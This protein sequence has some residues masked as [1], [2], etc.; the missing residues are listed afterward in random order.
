[1]IISFSS[2]WKKG[3]LGNCLFQ[4]A[5]TLGLAEKYN[6]EAVF[7]DWPF[8]Q[9][10]KDPLPHGEMQSME[11]KEK[12]FHYHDWQLKN[13]CNINGYLQS[14][15][16]FPKKL[17]FEFKD[18]FINPLKER[19]EF[20]KETIAISVRRGDYVN[21][22]LYYQIPM[23]W[24]ISAL[25]KEFPHWRDCNIII[26]SD[27]IDYCKI[28]FECLPNVY[29]PNG[30]EIEDLAMLTLCDNHI[31]ANSTFS[32]WGAYLS[33]SK[34]VVHCGKLMEGWLG[35]QSDIRDFY[36]ERWTLHEGQKPDLNDCTFTIPVFYD[37][38]DRKKNLE[39]SVCLIQQ[40]FDTKII[41]GEQGGKQFEYMSEYCQ[42]HNFSGMQYFH[43]TKMLNDMAMIAETPIIS[44]WDCDIILPP[45]QIWLTVEAIRKGAEMVFPYDGR[46]ARMPRGNWFCKLED[47]LDIG[48]VGNTKLTGKHGNPVPVSSVGGAVF[49]DKDSFIEGGMENEKMIS[50]G[51]EDCE[52]NDRFKTLGFK[53][54]RVGGC[55][56]HMDHYVGVN[57][58][59][60]NPFFRANHAEIDKIRKMNADEL[61]NYVDTWEWR[62][63]YTEHYYRRISEGAIQ[64]AKEVYS[65]LDEMGV[66]HDSVIDI[67]CGVGE[68][69]NDNP[70][71]IGVDYKT[72]VKSLMIPRERYFDCDLEKN[73]HIDIDKKFDLALCLEVAEHL[74]EHRAV[75]LVNMLCDLS[76]KVLFSAAIPK[77]GGTGHINEQW[78]TYWADIFAKFGF[79]PAKKQLRERIM[80]NDKIELWYKQ[81]IVLYE[82]GGKGSITNFVHPDYYTQIIQH[83]ENQRA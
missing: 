55:L 61:R 69:N 23:W 49:F 79:Y 80:F 7:P 60:S 17:P 30:S 35:D 62:H 3:R 1:M 2:L 28:H 43:R 29:F 34:K 37:H 11:V 51:P 78:Q 63:K 54:E 56:Y 16:Y 82:K 72:P 70:G 33:K 14:E 66:K 39:L 6:A 44:N 76:D 65:V 10:F 38:I 74:N 12:H 24:Y 52:R 68:W 18:E 47:S 50:F 9:Y 75:S 48:I 22:P 4:I 20:K 41:V 77:Q 40:S 71:Y 81:N 13:S 27:D 59:T 46:F 25:S 53:V 73:T 21:N 31:L 83:Y 32:W 15:K 58:S 36:P 8:E 64:S 5:G 26:F 19:E 57:S 67:G 42:Y 45:F